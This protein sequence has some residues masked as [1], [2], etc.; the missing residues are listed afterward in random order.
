[1]QIWIIYLD[2]WAKHVPVSHEHDIFV[3]HRDYL[4]IF[5]RI[6]FN[7]EL[8]QFN[9][10]H[11]GDHRHIRVNINLLISVSCSSAWRCKKKSTQN[12]HNIVFVIEFHLLRVEYIKYFTL[13][14]WHNWRWYKSAKIHIR[15]N[16]I[17]KINLQKK[18]HMN[19][20]FWLY[21]YF[22][23]KIVVFLLIL[24]LCKGTPKT[25]SKLQ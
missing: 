19:F 2:L 15:Q 12:G 20:M 1:M 13:E 7:L 17:L 25:D 6:E 23:R 18:C 11:F 21:F 24:L 8:I 16:T 5:W 4:C 10:I 22:L 3:F 9:S 14:W